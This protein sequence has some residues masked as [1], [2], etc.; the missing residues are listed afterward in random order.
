MDSIISFPTLIKEILIILIN[1]EGISERSLHNHNF[2]K[3]NKFSPDSI[4]NYLLLNGDIIFY[5]E[6]GEIYYKVASQYKNNF[7][8]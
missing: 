8:S 5:L 4:I 1:S 6:D 2:F 3:K 7:V